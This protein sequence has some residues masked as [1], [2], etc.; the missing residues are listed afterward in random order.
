MSFHKN[1]GTGRRPQ[2]S[3]EKTDLEFK[4]GRTQSPSRKTGTDEV[5]Q[6]IMTVDEVGPSVIGYWRHY[7]EGSLTGGRN[8]G[9]SFLT[10]EVF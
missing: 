2:V 8:E 6:R 10:E 7:K 1:S 5:S 4:R 3:K 9:D